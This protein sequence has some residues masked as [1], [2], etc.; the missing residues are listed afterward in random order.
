MGEIS[1]KQEPSSMPENLTP[2]CSSCSVELLAA[3][4]RLELSGQQNIP[5]VDGSAYLM[6]LTDIPQLTCGI[7]LQKIKKVSILTADCDTLRIMH[8][9]LWPDSNSC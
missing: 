6:E 3:L 1:T 9:M 5:E 4:Q 2:V 8:G 7:C